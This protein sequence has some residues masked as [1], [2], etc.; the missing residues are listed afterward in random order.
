M[1]LKDGAYKNVLDNLFDGLYLTDNRRII[2]YW[3]KAAEKIT[4]YT[5]GEVVGK[6]CGDNILNHIDRNG[7]NLCKG[8]CPLAVTLK[9]GKPHECEIYLHHKD[10][11]RL[12]VSVRVTPLTDETGAIIGAAELFTDISSRAVNEE[13]IKELEKLALLDNLTQLANRTYLERELNNRFEEKKRHDIPFGIL[14]LDID[15][16]KR[17]NDTFGHDAGDEVLKLIANTLKS[18]ARPFDFYGRWGGEEFIGIISNISK[19]RLSSLG[20][21]LRILVEN[22]FLNYKDQTIKATISIG[23]TLCLKNDTIDS[24]VRRA[25]TLLYKSK[26]GGRNR[27]TLG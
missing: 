9:D 20:D 5:A 11:H 19:K 16:F 27:L 23:A 1:V 10:G 4:G 21:R 7:N 26:T 13:K 25:D 12:P 3:N 6:S 8:P 22:A 24:L 2:T 18:N 17:V 15:H 14:F